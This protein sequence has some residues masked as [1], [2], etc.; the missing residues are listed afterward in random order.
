[1][2]RE[3]TVSPQDCNTS[4]NDEGAADGMVATEL[5]ATLRRGWMEL[6]A[7][8]REVHNRTHMPY[9]AWC[10]FCVRGKADSAPNRRRKSLGDKLQE[11]PV[12]S[13]D[14]LYMKASEAKTPAEKVKEESGSSRGRP[15]LI[16]KDSATAWVS[17][18]VVPVK[19]DA[20]RESGDLWKKLINLAASD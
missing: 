2:S 13:I 3:A 12:V 15:I 11:K 18:N 5:P 14:D 16:T 8:E 7:E 1:M 4:V 20:Q 19:G 9:R 6:T 17:A 10:E